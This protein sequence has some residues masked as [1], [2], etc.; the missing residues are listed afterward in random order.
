MR[1]DP[2]DRPLD[3]MLERLRVHAIR[4]QWHADQLDRW[5][6]TCPICVEPATL[7][8]PYDAGLELAEAASAVAWRALE[9]LEASC[10]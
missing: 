2:F 7:R 10:R 4:Y 8:E 1:P 3:A 6:T 5:D 9:L